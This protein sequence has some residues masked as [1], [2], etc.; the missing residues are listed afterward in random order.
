VAKVYKVYW[1]VIKG[2]GHTN[3][4]RLKPA[5]RTRLEGR[6]QAAA[7]LCDR[8]SWSHWAHLDTAT[9]P[10][11][12]LGSQSGGSVKMRPVALKPIGLP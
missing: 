1:G 3:P 11:A 7:A 2:V 9:G 8:Y 6:L 12:V 4:C 10:R 5:F